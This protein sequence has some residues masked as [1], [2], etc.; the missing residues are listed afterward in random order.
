[1]SD[2]RPRIASLAWW[3]RTKDGRWVVAQFPNPALGVWIVVSLL[4]AFDVWPHHNHALTDAGIGA[5]IVWG[6]DEVVRGVNP[7]R[8]L[9]GGVVLVLEV[10]SLAR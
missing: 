5:L 6:A 8:R 7:W 1:M 4:R 3:F 2:Q 9:L 10:Y